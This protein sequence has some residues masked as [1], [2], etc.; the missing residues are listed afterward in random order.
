VEVQMLALAFEY[1]YGPGLYCGN[2]IFIL[3][4]SHLFTPDR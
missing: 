3:N 2:R 4:I 1:S